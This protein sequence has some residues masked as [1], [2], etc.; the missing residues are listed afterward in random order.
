MNLGIERYRETINRLPITNPT[1]KD[2]NALTPHLPP[3]KAEEMLEGAKPGS[4]YDLFWNWLALPSLLVSDAYQRVYIVREEGGL[5]IGRGAAAGRLGTAK[6]DI[7]D[8]FA[9]EAV[10]YAKQTWGDRLVQDTWK[11]VVK[12]ILEDPLTAKGQDPDNE[13]V[14]YF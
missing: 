3:G 2:I 12:I 6:D 4:R 14:V 11:N 5:F 7:T 1:L 9:Q 10:D 8:Y 13:G